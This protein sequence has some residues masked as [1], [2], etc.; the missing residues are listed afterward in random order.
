MDL[1]KVIILIKMERTMN[2]NDCEQQKKYTISFFLKATLYTIAAV[3]LLGIV[4][5]FQK[6][7]EETIEAFNNNQ[8]IICSNIRLS[9]IVSKQKG[10]H[11]DTNYGNLIT[12]GDTVVNLST[13]KKRDTH[14]GK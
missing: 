9:T 1:S 14:N 2:T 3:I 10:Y 6:E 4:D 8:E 7:K 11:F 5:Q 13:C 12:N